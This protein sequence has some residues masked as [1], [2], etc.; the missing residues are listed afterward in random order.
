LFPLPNN[1]MMERIV[2]SCGQAIGIDCSSASKAGCVMLFSEPKSIV[3][4]NG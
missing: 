2:K 1:A 4:V 3:P